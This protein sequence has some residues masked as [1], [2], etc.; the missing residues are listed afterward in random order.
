MI[1]HVA[2]QGQKSGGCYKIYM[3]HG[4]FDGMNLWIQ[5]AV[6]IQRRELVC[7]LHNVCYVQHVTN[8]HC[9][10]NVGCALI[11]YTY[12]CTE[13]EMAKDR[14]D[15]LQGWLKLVKA[16]TENTLFKGG[17]KCETM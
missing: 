2:W 13:P 10:V 5:I 6:N 15:A 8:I 9:T 3:Y 14:M 17:G 16:K 12:V 1:V 4:A 7:I 11:Q